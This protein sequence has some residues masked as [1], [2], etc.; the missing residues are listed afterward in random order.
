MSQRHVLASSISLCISEFDH[1]F[2]FPHLL[3]FKTTS[4]SSEAALFGIL[5]FY[6]YIYIS[7]MYILRSNRDQLRKMQLQGLRL[8]IEPATL[9]L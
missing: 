1:S 2:F 6:T 9:N 7:K 8:G 3:L 4:T 5:A